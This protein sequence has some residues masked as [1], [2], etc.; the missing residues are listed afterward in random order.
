[1]AISVSLDAF[2]WAIDRWIGT[3]TNPSMTNSV[4]MTVFIVVDPLEGCRKFPGP[5]AG[6]IARLD[7]RRYVGNW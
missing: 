5:A 6:N 1:M 4:A 7:D 2:A 3:E